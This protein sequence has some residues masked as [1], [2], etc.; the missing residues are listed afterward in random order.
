M[1]VIGH[2]EI[3]SFFT[4]A[5]ANGN[6]SH[7][8]CFV[9]PE[10]VGKRAV[11]EEIAAKLLQTTKDKLKQSPDFFVVEQLYDEKDEKTKKDISIEQLQEL[12]GYLSRRAYLGDYKVAIIDEA[13]KMNSKAANALLKTLEEPTEKTVLFLITKDEAEL[14]KT[15]V[16][17][18][19]TI[20]F[21]PVKETEIVETLK[22]L[23]LNKVKAEELAHLS[24]GLPGLALDWQGDEEK[25]LWYLNEVKRV[26]GLMGKSFFEK[27]QAVEE[28]FGDKT[29]HIRERGKLQ[30]ILDIWQMVLRDNLYGNF[31][32]KELP[33]GQSNSV[34]KISP[35]LA[36]RI[37]N[38]INEAKDLLRQ[39]VHPRLIV[40]NILLLIP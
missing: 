4:K 26:N 33:A 40:E 12:C 7:A 18:C 21:H 8:Y 2:Q 6:L 36:V 30:K 32:W 28:L 37:Y 11:A 15:I 25:Y 3:K 34:K 10:K 19:Q 31:G 13:E 38:Q 29:D 22:S 14:P 39:N 1:D 5:I 20:Y 24:H 23:G 17:R 16:S 27:L 9:G 35:D